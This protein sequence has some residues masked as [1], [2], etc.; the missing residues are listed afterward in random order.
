MIGRLRT[1]LGRDDGF[2]LVELMVV[3][4]LLGV[5]GGVVTS[6]IVSAHQV[7][8]HTESR[9]QAVTDIH[10]TL[11]NVG[12]EIRAADAR[13]SANTALRS[14]SPSSLETDV[15]REEAGVL[16]RIR[17]TYT[18]T[19][20]TLSE[21]RRVWNDAATPSS[22][23][24]DSDTTRTRITGLVNAGTQPLFGYRNSNGA[25]ITGC[26][27]ANG[28]YLDGPVPA[29]TLSDVVEITITV[30]RSV[31]PGRP[32]IEVVTRVGLRNA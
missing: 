29:G 18:L 32:P 23:A 4:V 21:R 20:G 1:R 17:Y 11:A 28:V 2:T 9:V 16:Q 15:L 19:D 6:G 31:G 8:R 3:V 27:D 24:P 26:H 10:H 25:C 12:R 5:V 13:E 7:T 14:A 22:T 30:R